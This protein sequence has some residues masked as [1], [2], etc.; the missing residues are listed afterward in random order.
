VSHPT[1]D[2]AGTTLLRRE[3]K[4]CLFMAEAV[5]GRFDDT[6]VIVS[7]SS[8]GIGFG[9][10]TR[11]AEEGASVVVNDEGTGEGE[12]AAASIR[13]A[14]GEATFVRADIGDPD[15]VERLVE[16]TVDE[17]GR[18]DV[19]INNAGVWTETTSLEA[20]VADW[21]RV[22]D[23][24]LRGYWLCSK[25][26]AEQMPEGG[27][28]VNVASIHSIV[29]QVGLFPYNVAKTGIHGLTR[30]MAL[31]LGPDVRV[32]GINPGWIGV[33]RVRDE[34]TPEYEAELDSLHP[35]GRIGTTGDIAGTAAFLASE[36]AAFVTGETVTVDGGR[37]CVL[38]DDVIRDYAPE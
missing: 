32:N 22:L 34:I 24:D 15:E 38:Q 18:V 27:S 26:A 36:D 7:G 37:K 35:V 10:A 9:I 3:L 31:E 33:E 2:L 14:G 29:T 25:H 5:R 23:V 17:Y 13:D 30:A 1:H 8:R 21:D 12:D 20:T 28:I 19:L 4:S 6:I 16:A 11:F